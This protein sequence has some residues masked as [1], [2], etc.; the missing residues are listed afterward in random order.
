MKKLF[1]LLLSFLVFTSCKSP[2]TKSVISTKRPSKSVTAS[3]KAKSIINAAKYYKGTRYKY[4]GTSKSGMDC[5]GLVYT[6]FKKENQTTPRTTKDLSSFGKWVDVKR[7]TP[8][9]LIFF[10]TKRNSRKV[11]HV[12]IVTNASSNKNDIRFI[13]A[14]T[15]RGVI[16]SSLSEA[17]WYKAYVQS[18]RVL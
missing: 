14:S 3:P 6:A 18:R 12:G 7:L 13:H 16:I 8:G 10:A 1:V 5:S 17:Y 15:S 9:D 11:N 4:G 2:S